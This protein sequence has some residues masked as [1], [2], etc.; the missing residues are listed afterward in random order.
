MT[1]RRELMRKLVAMSI[2]GLLVTWLLPVARAAGPQCFGQN[3]TIVGTAGDDTLTGTGGRDVI[4]GLQGND[5]IFGK[6]GNDLLCG[7]DGNDMLHGQKGDDRVTG[8]DQEDFV[9]GGLGDDDLYG[10]GQCYCDG[11]IGGDTVSYEGAPRAVTV[12]LV[13]RTA[14]GHG[15]DKVTNFAEIHG[16]AFDDTLKGGA[17]ASAGIV[18]EGNA[19][20]D[21]I[22]GN[23][24]PF[25][26]EDRLFGGSG[27][28]RI[29]PLADAALVEGG[30]GNDTLDGGAGPGEFE[31]Y[32][33]S[34]A[35]ARRSVV[36]DLAAGEATGQGTDRIVAFTGVQG[37]AFGDI[38]RG[39]AEADRLIGAGGDDSIIGRRGPDDLSGLGGRDTLR[40]NR[41]GDYL[42][43][44]DGVGAN[45]T[46]YGGKNDDVCSLDS[47]DKVV[48]CETRYSV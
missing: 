33:V 39:S 43:T 11:K 6:G 29:H 38:L 15:T 34:F 13:A 45:D 26:Y 19:G 2:A 20:N 28:D 23:N 4:A 10:G 14:S 3:A 25:A 46:G 17:N 37:S 30:A 41:G 5:L 24:S 8:D 18:I 48:S 36:V 12:D 40:G 31:N 1:A 47:G 16:S 7:D 42:D 21:S 44:R 22:F 27:N 9:T 35:H 32:I